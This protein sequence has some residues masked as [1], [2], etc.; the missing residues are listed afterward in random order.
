MPV[1]LRQ[2]LLL[3]CDRLRWQDDR[4]RLAQPVLQQK[5]DVLRT[6]CILRGTKTIVRVGKAEQRH[7]R[8]DLRTNC[9][10]GKGSEVVAPNGG[11]PSD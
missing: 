3:R 5:Q 10:E 2:D 7:A 8:A 11:C 6:Q 1:Y 4:N 9:A